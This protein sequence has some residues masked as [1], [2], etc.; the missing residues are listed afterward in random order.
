M[1]TEEKDLVLP[2]GV[3]KAP[4]D[5]LEPDDLKALQDI[6]TS[7]RILCN[8]TA[9]L[10]ARSINLPD[11]LSECG[12]CYFFNCWRT[13]KPIPGAD[14]ASF[15]AYEPNSRERIQIKG[16][17]VEEDL[18]S[19]GPKSVWDRLFFVD[20][21][22]EGKWDYTFDVYPIDTA[23]IL[24][25]KVNKHETFL[26]HQRQQRRPRLSIVRS[27]IRPLGL[28]PQFTC[29]LHNGTVTQYY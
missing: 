25:V 18:T 15:D 29:D 6:Y 14:H 21:Y 22:K 9:A 11:A 24:N 17:S 1:I 28:K 26:D 3:F 12:F 5:I 4:V 7:W 10:N 13:S 19:F 27:I 23:T 16:S 8:Q 20:F 2:D